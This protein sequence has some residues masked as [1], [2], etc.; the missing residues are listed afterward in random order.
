[1]TH[2]EGDQVWIPHSIHGYC[3]GKVTSLGDKKI[4]NVQLLESNEEIKVNQQSILPYNSSDDKN[5]NDMVEIQDLSE[6]II[7]N[8]LNI[9]YKS[10]E[11][12]TYIGNVLISINPYKNLNIY[13]NEILNQ[14]KD[15]NFLKEKSPHIYAVSLRAYQSMVSEKKN[16]SIIISGESGS[17]KTEA[18]K[19]ILQFLINT[20][21]SNINNNNNN[22]SI[23]KDILTSNPI[24]EA[25]G[26]SRTTKNHNSSRFGKFLK[27]EFRS[28]DFKIDGASIET[29]LLEKSRISH[30]PDRSNLSYH[31]FYYLVWGAS[32]DERKLWG[33]ENDPSKYRYLD[34]N[35][36]VLDSFKNQSMNPQKS[37]ES[38]KLIKQSMESM[39]ISKEQCDNIFLILAA[40]LHLGN[41]E[42]EKDDNGFSS[43]SQKPQVL[44]A[45]AQVSK[46]LGYSELVFK[47][48][49]INRNLKS[50][51]RGSVYCRP[52]EV[53]QSEQTRDAL[54]KSL[55]VKL[56]SHIVEK[57]NLKFLQNTTSR[58]LAGG[59]DK[60]N[61]LFIG[62]LDIFG[63]ENLSSNNLEQ[64][65]INFTNEKLQQQFNLN[66]F[67]NE[68]KEYLAEGIPWSSSNFI[69][70]K[71]CIELVE[72]K[73]FGILSLLDDECL[74]P[75]GS[76]TALLEKYSKQYHNTN[77]YYIRT[78]AKGTLGIKHFAGD[79]TYQT[80]NWLEKNRDTVSGDVEALL[81][82]SSNQLVKSL[83]SPSSTAPPN[84][85]QSPPSPSNTTAKASPP[86]ERFNSNI[87]SGSS[88]NNSGNNPLSNSGSHN[89][90]KSTQ[91]LTVSGH[92]VEQLN[93]LIGTINSTSVHYVRCIKPNITMDPNNFNNLHV[94][95]Q[96]RNVGVLNTIKV[97]KM[98]YSYRRD[99]N[100]FLSRYKCINKNGK[101]N[102]NNNQLCKI[103]LENVNS[104]IKITTTT[105]NKPNFQIGKTKIFISDE[106]YIALENNRYSSIVESVKV[107]QSFFKMLKLKS[108]FKKRLDSSKHLQT[109]IRSHI[110]RKEYHQ[111][112]IQENKRKEEEHKKELER[113]RKE[114]E[115]RQKELE[116]KRK[117]EEKEMERKR[118]EDEERQ[119]E[120]ERK[121][122]EEEKKRLKEEEK[123]KKEEE[124]LRKE[125]EKK[126]NKEQKQ[127]FGLKMF[128]SMLTKSISSSTSNEDISGSNHE[129]GSL[130][131]TNNTTTTTTTTTSSIIVSSDSAFESTS[132]SLPSSI[133]A[134]PPP[135][136]KTQPIGIPSSN[137]NNNASN[138]KQT[139]VWT[140]SPTIAGRQLT[141]EKSRARIGRLTIRSASPLTLMGGDISIGLKP[142]AQSLTTSPPDNILKPIAKRNGF[143][144]EPSSPSSS[145]S[146]SP[147]SLSPSTSTD[148]LMNGMVGT[149]HLNFLDGPISNGPLGESLEEK[150]KRFRIKIVK[151][152]IVTEKDYVRDL[153]IVIDVFLN[154]IKEKGLLSPKDIQ[155]LFSN[156]EILI[157]VN[158]NVLKE[159]EKH[160]DPTYEN[161]N[162][163]KAFLDMSHYL[164]MYTAYCSHQEA[165]LKLL[166]EEKLK[167]P[168][169]REFLDSCMNDPR[170]RG[171]PLNSFII[172]PVQR[173]CKY[174][175]LI[176]EVIRFTPDDHPDRAPLEE[177]D[178]KISD[179]VQSINEA[180]RTLEIFQ[181]IVE[182]QNSIDGLEDT[183]LM[184]KGRTFLMEGIVSSVKELNSEDSLSRTIYLFNNLILICSSGTNVLSSTINQ[185]KSKKLK[186]KAKIPINFARLMF[187]S[188]TDSVK[189]AL[190]IINTKENSNY[191]L[192]FNNDQDRTKWFKQIKSLIQETKFSVV[193][194]SSKK[195]N[196]I[197][198]SRLSLT[199]S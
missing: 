73:S 59:V 162:I 19:T 141:K 127:T 42:F 164:K 191:I 83:F 135:P 100:Q 105:N 183:D 66:V 16:Q 178:K 172:K 117:E 49:L 50:G 94:L 197:G 169:F 161:V 75:K 156:I 148:N 120:L 147:H 14:Y 152:I 145:S 77:Q 80:E 188:D 52:M 133:P 193:N 190:E 72:K 8:N 179:I 20:S 40:I 82:A 58:D 103:I 151:E 31:I 125:E 89:I 48:S 118:K 34:A 129:S 17:G 92:F 88:A 45:V 173:I 62:V 99:F 134:P 146:V 11:I 71:E 139:T 12:Y 57:I 86:R 27:I 60:K 106:L 121:K 37:D 95:H 119:K 107:I 132:P 54:S 29:Y 64:L 163:G 97:R 185:F 113:Q 23:E 112:V 85:Q 137:N 160:Q 174:P 91:S 65:L 43:V 33:L 126:N 1:M 143:A 136:V 18:S 195:L 140:H 104:S 5:F 130:Q 159:L 26:N 25:F 39:S 109:L 198:Q 10:D 87:N 101:N 46:L 68:Q 157:S 22:N 74:M 35:K 36:D 123:L 199:T 32:S 196:T 67:E 4:I 192:C 47:Q 153:Y 144:T 56:F 28:S 3:K 182:L 158:S 69:D 170:C 78:L 155:T 168:A 166:E 116:R 79:V 150:N 84:T 187:V 38:F 122:K 194:S 115:E 93:R 167:N 184:E 61:N 24:L 111:L 114:E 149:N 51:G 41:I 9:R 154:Q 128:S 6:A 15:I 165:A 131:S 189:Y 2:I 181:K 180:K 98:G 171:L 138:I 53:S 44:E 186:L 30:R 102:S 90:K 7:L 96:L 70:N 55:Y 76:E 142:T 124:K 108:D 63:F 175:L 81:V 176:K 110:K 21:G 13:S 177:V